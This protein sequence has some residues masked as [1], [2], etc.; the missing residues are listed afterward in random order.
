MSRADRYADLVRDAGQSID[1]NGGA[2]CPLCGYWMKVAH[3]FEC[4]GC[5]RSRGTTSDE[6]EDALAKLAEARGV[7]AQDDDTDWPEGE[8]MDPAA[9]PL[10][11]LPQI[12]GWPTGHPGAS[13]SFTGP[14][15]PSRP[16][17]VSGY[18]RRIAGRRSSATG[19]QAI[20]R[21]TP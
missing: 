11:P 14:R 12:P 20:L 17:R 8:P 15:P 6:I 21:A 10:E 3:G 9:V 5:G 13:A 1:D 16:T 4:T 19:R 2:T 18:S 7:G